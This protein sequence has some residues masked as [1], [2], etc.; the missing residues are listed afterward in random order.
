MPDTHAVP[1][2]TW[3]WA[4]I[5]KEDLAPG[6]VRQ[7]IYGGALMICRLTFAA[8]TVTTP[9]EH[10]HERAAVPVRRQRQRRRERGNGAQVDRRG[11]LRRRGGAQSGRQQGDSPAAKP[12]IQD[13]L[14]TRRE[15]PAKCRLTT[16]S[17]ASAPSNPQ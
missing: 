9:H 13:H 17:L 6:V 12:G 5:P 2:Q 3:N 14:G 16:C 11:R 7:M 4:S 15:R 10:F 1:H 8:G